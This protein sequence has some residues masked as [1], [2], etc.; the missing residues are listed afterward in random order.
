MLEGRVTEFHGVPVPDI[1]RTIP[2][3]VSM[4]LQLPST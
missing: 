4:P 2:Y 1:N 3:P